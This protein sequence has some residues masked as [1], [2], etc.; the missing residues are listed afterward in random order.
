[1]EKNV[2]QVLA[3]SEEMRQRGSQPS[4]RILQFESA[5]PSEEVKEALGLGVGEKI[6]R[7]KRVRLADS[8]SLCVE[9]THLP[10]RFFPDLLEKYDPRT[11]L[12]QELGKHYGIQI[13]LPDEIAVA[14]LATTAI[15]KSIA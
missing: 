4:S 8:I 11:S 14:P 2:R 3:F 5:A 15:P 1:M 9:C 7:L 12:Y 13:V 6:V 10:L